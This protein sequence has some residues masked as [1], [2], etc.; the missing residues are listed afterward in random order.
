MIRKILTVLLSAVISLTCA[1]GLAACAGKDGK[2]GVNGS[3]GI[4]GVGIETVYIDENGDLIIVYTDGR[5]HN[6]GSVRPQD[7]D[8]EGLFF[9]EVTE[10]GQKVGYSVGGLGTATGRTINIPSQYGGLPVVAID[11]QAFYGCDAIT[12][13][14]IPD[15]VKTVGEKAFYECSSLRTVSIG[16]GVEFFG[17]NAFGRCGNLGRVNIADA[18]KWC[19]ASFENA[20]A[21]PLYFA[22][23][24][25]VNGTQVSDLV[26]SD[27]VQKIGDY[28]FYGC[29]NIKS[30]KIGSGALSIGEQAFTECINLESVTIGAN[31]L[32]LGGSAFLG[33]SKLK[34]VDLGEK[35]KTLGEYCFANCPEINEITIPASAESIDEGAFTECYGLRTVNLSYGLKTIGECAFVGCTALENFKMPDSVTEIGMGMLMFGGGAGFQESDAENSLKTLTVSNALTLIPDFAFNGCAM[36]ELVIGNRVETINYSAFFDCANLKRVIMPKSVKKI[37]SYAFYKCLALEEVFY[38]GTEEE[39]AQIKIGKNGN[40]IKNVPVYFYSEE[41][42]AADGNFWRYVDG[43]PAIWKTV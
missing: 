23:E 34:Q 19:E 36:S 3:N 33:C 31:V 30:V 26:I 32:T 38:L 18:D 20:A 2:D 43:K 39:W 16:K 37:V 42:P 35:I 40:D 25:F 14:T 28:A 5:T 12:N 4:D 10:G 9:S 41:Q 15:S 22:K 6:A 13:V 11:V 8:T 21:S 17:S 7:G 27:S 29:D 24:L 1:F